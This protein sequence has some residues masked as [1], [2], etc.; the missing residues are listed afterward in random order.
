MK[1]RVNLTEDDLEDLEQLVASSAHEPRKHGPL[2]IA[3]VVGV[4]S[5]YAL[6]RRGYLGEEASAVPSLMWLAFAVAVLFSRFH[7]RSVLAK[8][9]RLGAIEFDLAAESSGLRVTTLES[10]ELIPWDSLS[11]FV[12][13]ERYFLAFRE[14]GSLLVIPKRAFVSEAETAEFWEAARKRYVRARYHGGAV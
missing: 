2:R 12:D 7:R 9:P 14:D 4:L 8:P 3:G 11:N 13:A 6:A 10:Q 5:L 1:I